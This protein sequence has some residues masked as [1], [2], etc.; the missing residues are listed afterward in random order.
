[1]AGAVLGV[2]LLVEGVV[3]GLP[4][5]DGGGGT[6]PPELLALPGMPGRHTSTQRPFWFMYDQES[7]QPSNW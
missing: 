5:T 6:N 7:A 2:E 1:M 3:V 4:V